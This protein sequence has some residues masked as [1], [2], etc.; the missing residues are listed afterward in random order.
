MLHPLCGRLIPSVTSG[1]DI[2]HIGITEHY[3]AEHERDALNGPIFSILDHLNIGRH[4]VILP[5]QLRQ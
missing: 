4:Y 2:I 3:Y 1:L 5:H